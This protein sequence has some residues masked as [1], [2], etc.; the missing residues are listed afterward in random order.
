MVLVKQADGHRNSNMTYLLSR[1]I[2]FFGLCFAVGFL[3]LS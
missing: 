3:I 2:L 1:P